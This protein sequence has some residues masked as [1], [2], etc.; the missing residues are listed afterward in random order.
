[1]RVVIAVLGLSLLVTAGCQNSP[2]P[3]AAEP[4]RRV[5]DVAPAILEEPANH[6]RP[7][8][9]TS[10]DAQQHFDRGL[11]YLYAFNHDEAIRSFERAAALDPACAMAHWG[12]ALASGPHINNP[13]MPVVRA[14]AAWAALARAQK[15]APAGTDV[16]QA[17][18]AALAKRYADP[19]PED[20]KPLDEAYAA[21]MRAV[22]KRFPRDADVGALFAESL[23]DLR[24]WDLWSADGEPRPQTPEVLATLESVLKLAPNHPLALHLYIHAVEAS[25]TPQKADVAADRLRHLAP[26]LGHLVHMPAHI[27]LRLGG[28]QQAILANERAIAADTRYRRAVPQQ[29]FY[30]MYMAHNRHMLAFAAMMQ[31][32]S[33]RALDSVRAMLAEIPEAWVGKA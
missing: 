31:G 13:A 22:H 12:V 24:P 16:E 10:R 27:D 18:I 32:E 17:L 28:W 4:S 1:M 14:K 33:K 15:H 19:Q 11:R 26:D 5:R 2:L 30:R 3:A 25:P 8:T 9:T 21:A 29:D 6:D 7:V 23:M 20:R